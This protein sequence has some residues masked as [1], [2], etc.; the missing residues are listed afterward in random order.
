MSKLKN[1]H[2]CENL[3]SQ[4]VV[5]YYSS[6]KNDV[7]NSTVEESENNATDHCEMFE[8][9][10]LK[11]MILNRS[12][13]TIFYAGERYLKL[14]LTKKAHIIEIANLAQKALGTGLIVREHFARLFLE[15]DI[16]KEKSS[17]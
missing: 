16:Q 6:T 5:I 3:D 9:K 11:R 14:Q 10:E 1:I 7:I 15:N 17:N 12:T 13:V 8:I 4:V 2:F